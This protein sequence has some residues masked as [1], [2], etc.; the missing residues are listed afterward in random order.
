MKLNIKEAIKFCKHI[1]TVDG[2]CEGSYSCK[3]CPGHTTYNNGIACTKNGWTGDGKK[4]YTMKEMDLQT[5]ASCKKWLSEH[6]TNIYVE[7]L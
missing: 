1:I 4:D 3:N 6:E 7:E 5:L 2:C